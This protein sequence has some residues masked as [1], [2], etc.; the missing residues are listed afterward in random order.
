MPQS[1]LKSSGPGYVQYLR[2][3]YIATSYHT[4]FWLF[5]DSID[6]WCIL[7]GMLLLQL[8]FLRDKPPSNSIVVSRPAYTEAGRQCWLVGAVP[9]SIP[10][11]Q[12][13]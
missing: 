13:T 6:S 2:T 11:M 12:R 10:K 7:P 5:T 9:F 8:V 1:I 3:P 4:V